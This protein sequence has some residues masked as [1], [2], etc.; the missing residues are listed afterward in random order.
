VPA[1]IFTTIVAAR[2]PFVLAELVLGAP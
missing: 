2:R 1:G